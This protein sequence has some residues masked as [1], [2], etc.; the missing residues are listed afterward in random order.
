MVKF[1]KTGLRLLKVCGL[2]FRSFACTIH[3]G[4]EF[5]GFRDSG[6]S[7]FMVSRIRCFMYGGQCVRN[8]CDSRFQN[9]MNSMF[10]DS[11]ASMYR[12][13]QGSDIRCLGVWIECFSVSGCYGFG[14]AC[15]RNLWL[16]KIRTSQN[17]VFREMKS[18]R[19]SSFVFGVFIYRCVSRC[20]D[21]GPSSRRNIGPSGRHGSRISRFWISRLLNFAMCENL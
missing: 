21:F 14:F 19:I 8:I 10:V 3:R 18:L 1:W 13:Y 16:Y 20:R 4:F 7:R 6:I 5:L 11:G 15:F 12:N 17:S 2:T 9:F